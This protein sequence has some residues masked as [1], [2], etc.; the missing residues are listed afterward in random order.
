MKIV[1]IAV[2]IVGAIGIARAE[3]AH[4]NPMPDASKKDECVFVRHISSWRVL[5]SGNVVLFTANARRAYLAQLGPPA[6]DLTHAFKVAFIDRDGDAQLCGRSRDKVQAVGSLVRQPATITSMTRLDETGLQ[7]LEAKYDVKLT[8]K[9][10]D[11]TA[12]E[13]PDTE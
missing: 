12:D 10:D 11:K 3:P 7:Q 8:R 5:D 6:S 9:K 4:R 13:P 2:W 1:L